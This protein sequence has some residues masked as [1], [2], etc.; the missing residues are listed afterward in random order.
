MTRRLA[1]PTASDW[2]R[3]LRDFGYSVAVDN[4]AGPQTYGALFAYMGAKDTASAFGGAAS[5]YFPAFSITTGIRIAHFI[6]QAAV[7]T[8]DFHYLREIWGPT[9][10]QLGYEGRTDLGNTEPGDGFRFRG[11]G[12]FMI[13]GRDNYARYGKRMGLDLVDQPDLAAQPD[14][15]LHIACLYWNDHR[16]NIYADADNILAV[17]N[18]IN[19]GNPGSIR[20]PNGYAARKA[21]LAKAKAVLC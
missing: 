7:E 17:S 2:Q 18:G 9:E 11:R 14:A 6:A 5:L 8:G 3:K 15:A 4:V 20:E 13:T 12:V 1:A 21:A 10:A 19:R 16:L